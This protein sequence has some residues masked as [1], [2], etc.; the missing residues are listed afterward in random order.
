MSLEELRSGLNKAM[1]NPE[2][3]DFSKQLVTMVA[4][5]V[6]DRPRPPGAAVGDEVTLACNTQLTEQIT[7]KS[8]APMPESEREAL[9]VVMSKDYVPLGMSNANRK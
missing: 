4:T 1:A 2:V 9:K 7:I 8:A 5:N 6:F 3:P